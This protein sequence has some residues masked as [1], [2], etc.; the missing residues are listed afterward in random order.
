[1][2]RG[3]ERASLVIDVGDYMG[4]L[5]GKVGLMYTHVSSSKSGPQDMIG[6]V[7]GRKWRMESVLSF[8]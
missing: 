3:K 4:R 2:G 8:C 7:K 6:R 1:M 5:V